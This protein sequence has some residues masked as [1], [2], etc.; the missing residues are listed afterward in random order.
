MVSKSSFPFAF[1]INPPPPGQ[2][3]GGTHPTGMHSCKR[4][5]FSTFI[6]KLTRS[7]FLVYPST[8]VPILG[9]H[10]IYQ[11]ILQ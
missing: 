10:I 2:C 8:Q 1:T 4:S 6:S 11:N 5:K 7:N 9:V 3:V